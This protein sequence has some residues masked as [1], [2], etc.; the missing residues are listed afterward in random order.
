MPDDDDALL[1]AKE[2]PQALEQVRAVYHR[3]HRYQVAWRRLRE[4]HFDVDPVPIYDPPTL[5]MCDV[6]DC[7]VSPTLRARTYAD[8]LAAI[9]TQAD[10]ALADLESGKLGAVDAAI[11]AA[12]ALKSLWAE[13]IRSLGP[14]VF[15]RRDR[16][17]SLGSVALQSSAG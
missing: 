10:A 11:A 16:C 13:Q 3:V 5:K 12:D 2:G 4:F 6:L 1:A 8:R 7:E 15:I 14:I 17:R 9:K